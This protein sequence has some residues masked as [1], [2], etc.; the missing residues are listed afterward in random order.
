MTSL[1]PTSASIGADT[2][3]VK[4][5]CASPCTF[6]AARST[7]EPARTCPTACSAVN[8][9]ATATCTFP[10]APPSPSRS[11]FT[12][13]TASATVLCIFQFPQTNLRR[14]T[15]LLQDL[16]AG[17]LAALD[18]LERRAAAGGHVRH[19]LDEPGLLDGGR[20]V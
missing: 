6:W 10:A 19:L 15:S 11:S 20:A 18:E 16:D 9:G 13:A 1:Q 3:P 4:A 8:G 14:A 17:Q 5:P 2:S 7:D 12:S